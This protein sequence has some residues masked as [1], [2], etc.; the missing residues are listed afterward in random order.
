MN[1]R[2]IRSVGLVIAMLIPASGLVALTSGVAGATTS[3]HKITTA[4]FTFTVTVTKHVTETC[5]TSGTN[6]KEWT[7]THTAT[8]DVTRTENTHNL[9][10][11]CSST[12][13]KITTTLGTA[14][15]ASFTI[16][17]KGF[18]VISSTVGQAYAN[19]VEFSLT[20]GSQACTIEFTQ[21]IAFT[22][23]LSG[24]KWETTTIF[25]SGKVSV[26]PATGKCS[27]LKTLLTKSTAQFSATIRFSPGLP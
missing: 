24:Q 23:T 18:G 25:T 7:T 9:K 4:K 8:T 1:S 5:G 10:S 17:P 15:T 21:S 12:T 11:T 26:A 16:L 22:G 3:T 13:A 27:T 6:T 19:G 14:T 2:M 20:F